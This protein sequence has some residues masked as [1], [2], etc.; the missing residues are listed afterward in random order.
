MII[1]YNE[2]SFFIIV[3][4]GLHSSIFTITKLIQKLDMHEL[5]TRGTWSSILKPNVSASNCKSCCCLRH[6]FAW[7]MAVQCTVKKSVFKA[8]LG[9]QIPLDSTRS[10]CQCPT[11]TS[12]SLKPFLNKMCQK[13]KK[14]KDVVCKVNSHLAQIPLYIVRCAVWIFLNMIHI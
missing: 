4:S 7:Y 6:N 8:I 10:N 12:I 11:C 2:W 1:N 5:L 3:I 9:G 14:K 13:K